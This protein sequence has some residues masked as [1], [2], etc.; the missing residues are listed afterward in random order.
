MSSQSEL[1]VAIEPE[2]ER[3]FGP[4]PCSGNMT[5]RVWGYVC[6]DDETVAA[7]FVEWTPGHQDRAANFDLIIGTW[8]PGASASDRAAVALEFRH[9]PTGPA[10]MVIDAAERPAG[11][12]SLVGEALKREQV[13]RQP[14]ATTAFALCDCV[15]AQDGRIDELRRP[16]PPGEIAGPPAPDGRGS[17]FG[18]A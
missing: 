4:C 5:R 14:I 15:Y 11:V 1:R 13:I 8:G 18:F 6:Q 7:Y 9:V 16:V 17:V 10:F 3:T 12:S 2:N